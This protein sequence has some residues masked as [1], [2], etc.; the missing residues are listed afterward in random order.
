LE[1]SPKRQKTAMARR[2]G[3]PARPSED[4]RVAVLTLFVVVDI[5]LM[6]PN[7]PRNQDNESGNSSDAGEN[8]HAIRPP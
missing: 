6:P 2:L 8:Q 4:R 5:T 7:P 3:L 1:E